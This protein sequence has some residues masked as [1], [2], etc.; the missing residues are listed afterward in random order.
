M[1]FNLL[2]LAATYIVYTQRG[3]HG[4]IHLDDED[5]DHFLNQ[6]TARRW[7]MGKQNNSTNAPQSGTPRVLLIQKSSEKEER[8][9]RSTPKETPWLGKIQA[10][11]AEGKQRIAAYSQQNAYASNHKA[12]HAQN[13]NDRQASN[14]NAKQTSI[15]VRPQGSSRSVIKFDDMSAGSS[16]MQHSR[17]ST[18]TKVNLF[19]HKSRQKSKRPSSA[20]SVE[21]SI[22]SQFDGTRRSRTTNFKHNQSRKEVAFMGSKRVLSDLQY[23][24]PKMTHLPY[25]QQS[26]K[27]SVV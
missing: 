7:R 3:K 15:S 10:T 4:A 11:M 27:R 5:D 14:H 26:S 24:A 20:R 19:D 8:E 12:R 13:S 2:F 18:D 1:L 25:K 23:E 22:R 9:E 6:P 16:L 21:T 17:R